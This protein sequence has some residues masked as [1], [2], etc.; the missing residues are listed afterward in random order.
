MLLKDCP[1]GSVVRCIKWGKW[2]ID[3]HIPNYIKGCFVVYE[4]DSG[5]KYIQDKEGLEW[6]DYEC[7]DDDYEIVSFPSKESKA[8]AIVLDGVTYK[9]TPITERKK[10]EIDGVVYE[11]E[12]V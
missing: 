7:D 5:H 12:P 4:S 10:I 3:G 1:V 8:R 9:L 6:L 11:M 2:G